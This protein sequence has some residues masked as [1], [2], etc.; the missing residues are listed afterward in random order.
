M[1]TLSVGDF[2]RAEHST[3]GHHVD[4]KVPFPEHVSECGWAD[5]L[6]DRADSVFG[7]YMR[8]VV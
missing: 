5:S 3:I 6:P 7:F 4:E 1:G 8:N 2:G